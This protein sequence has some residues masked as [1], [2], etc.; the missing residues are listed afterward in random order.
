MHPFLLLCFLNLFNQKLIYWFLTAATK[1]IKN[2]FEFIG[3]CHP[4]I[5]TFF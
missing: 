3:A 4:K 2:L 1:K 5:T